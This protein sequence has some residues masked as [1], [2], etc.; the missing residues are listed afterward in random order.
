MLILLPAT[1]GGVERA[2][3]MYADLAG[4]Q[5]PG[6]LATAAGL[7]VTSLIVGVGKVGSGRL[8]LQLAVCVMVV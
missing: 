6:A 2:V 4:A 1:T 7:A 8:G 5:V 3:Q